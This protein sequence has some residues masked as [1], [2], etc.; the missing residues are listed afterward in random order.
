MCAAERISAPGHCPL[1]SFD[2]G[3]EQITSGEVAKLVLLLDDR[4]L[5]ARAQEAG[6]LSVE[7][8]RQR[9]QGSEATAL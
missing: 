5:E 3:S 2:G 1:T 8:R 4:S 9:A 7:F 6:D